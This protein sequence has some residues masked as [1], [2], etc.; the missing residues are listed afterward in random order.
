MTYSYTTTETSTFSLTIAKYVTSK[1]KTDLRQF[2]RWYGKP[3]D[4]EIDDYAEEL[5]VMLA[6]GYV[7][8]VEYGFRRDGDWVVSLRY[9]AGA[10]G[11]LNADTRAGGVPRGHDVSKANFT[12]FMHRSSTWWDLT[13]GERDAI[14][15]NLPIK[16]VSGQE[17]GYVAGSFTYDRTYSS[18]GNGIAR[19]TFTPR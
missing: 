16:R 9:E 19:R 3:P 2:Q 17:P 7:K 8:W 18:S 11:T 4:A 13:S 6:G 10:D 5:I 15:A 1:V 14:Y 12:S